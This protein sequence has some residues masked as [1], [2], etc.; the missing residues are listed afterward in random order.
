MLSW[1]RHG[2]SHRNF[3]FLLL[4]SDV[5]VAAVTVVYWKGHPQVTHSAEFT[6]KD[7]FHSK[8]FG[9]LL[10]DVEDIGVAI[11]AVQPFDMGFMGKEGRRY[12]GP[13]GPKVRQSASARSGDRLSCSLI[14]AFFIIR[15]LPFSTS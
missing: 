15:I 14:T 5:R 10:L 11:A 12:M 3:D 1:K 9:A 7:I 6:F 8:V 2:R 13:F 4:I